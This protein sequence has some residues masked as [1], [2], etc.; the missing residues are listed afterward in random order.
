MAARETDIVAV[1]EEEE[2]DETVAVLDAVTTNV[3]SA[4]PSSASVTAAT[5]TQLVAV[6]AAPSECNEAEEDDNMSST[7]PKS[8]TVA[9]VSSSTL[10]SVPTDANSNLPTSPT[11]DV[12]RLTETVTAMV[13]IDT[14]ND[15]FALMVFLITI[16]S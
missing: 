5:E 10:P 6:E 11:A 1:A 12:A 2:D 4:Q 15:P 14:G 9:A 7:I 8:L 13:T 3:L 16:Q